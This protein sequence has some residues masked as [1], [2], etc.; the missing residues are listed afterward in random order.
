MKTRVRINRTFL[1]LLVRKGKERKHLCGILGLISAGNGKSIPAVLS[2]CSPKGFVVR[3]GRKQKVTLA[4]LYHVS[5]L[6]SY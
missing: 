6:Q 5:Y 2:E 4:L 3:S 1:T